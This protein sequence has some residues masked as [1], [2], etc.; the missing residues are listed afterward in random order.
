M[1]ERISLCLLE[2]TFPRGLLSAVWLLS[3]DSSLFQGSG[4]T[5][6]SGISQNFWEEA[7]T[8]S[9]KPHPPHGPVPCHP[10]GYHC[11]PLIR[12]QGLVWNSS[13]RL[14]DYPGHPDKPR[15]H[16]LGP[17]ELSRPLCSAS[18]PVVNYWVRLV[19]YLW[20]DTGPGG[21]GALAGRAG[22][23]SE[24]QRVYSSSSP[25]SD[26]SLWAYLENTTAIL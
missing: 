20:A 18:C 4:W 3:A 8:T 1:E 9:R 17:T 23:S 21:L 25:L 10:P 14:W 26:P 22:G 19:P 12:G 16:T 7:S 6:L 15:E 2:A 5:S 11:Q 13:F 24:E